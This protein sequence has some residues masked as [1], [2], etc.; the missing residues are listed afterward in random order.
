MDTPKIRIGKDFTII[1]RIYKKENEVKTPY[2]L[3]AGKENYILRLWTP[4]GKQEI[5][6]FEINE[7]AIQ[8]DFLGKD[9]KHLGNYSLELIE[10]KNAIGM[11]TVDTTGFTLVAFSRYETTGGDSDIVIQD[12]KLE[13]ELGLAPIVSLNID[14]EFSEISH[15]A[16]SN[17]VITTEFKKVNDKIKDL[18]SEV[19]KLDIESIE[20]AI[21]GKQDSI[22]DLETIRQGAAKG[23]TAVQNVSSSNAN[24]ATVSREGFEWIITPRTK[25]ISEAGDPFFNSSGIADAYDVK[26]ELVK[27]VDKLIGKQLSTEDFTT[28]LKQKLQGLSNYDDSTLTSAINS[29]QSQINTLVSGNVSSAIDTFN[30]I[31]AF[32]DGVKDTQDL[33]GIIASIEQQIAGVN[34]TLSA[35]LAKKPNKTDIATING[36]L[37]TNG[38]NIVIEGK[39]YDAVIEQQQTKL[40]ELSEEVEEI[41]EKI[42]NLPQG[43]SMTPI[44]YADLV[45]LRDN[46]ELVAGSYYRITDYITTTAQENTQSACHPFDVIVLALSENTIAEEAYAIQSARD[47]DGYFANSNLAAWKLWYSLDNNAE[48]FAWA[49]NVDCI[50]NEDGNK[51]LRYPS[52]DTTNN[53]TSFCAWYNDNESV[54]VYTDSSYPMGGELVYDENFEEDWYI[55]EVLSKGKGVIYR[56]IDEW[57]NDVPYDFKNIQF[58]RYILEAADA[59]ATDVAKGGEL[60][61]VKEKLQEMSHKIHTNFWYYGEYV[62]DVYPDAN[63][64]TRY[65]PFGDVDYNNE[66]PQVLCEI[67]EN[68]Y[69]WFYT[70]HNE[71][72]DA[73]LQKPNVDEGLG[74]YDNT[75]KDSCYVFL[76]EEGTGSYY[77]TNINAQ[78]LN[79]IV[80]V[81]NYCNSNSFGNNCYFNSFGNNCYSNSFGNSCY[82]N[83][84]GNDCYSNSFGNNCYFNSFGN[85]C[86]FNSF[87]NDC[88]SNS[89]KDQDGIAD[90]ARYNKLDDGVNNIELWYDDNNGNYGELKNHHVC[91]GCRNRRIEIY[92][93][94]DYETTYTMT[95]DGELREFVLGDL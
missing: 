34:S 9:Q 45:N 71:D 52:R 31:I 43:A 23:A 37:L 74:V 61:I 26:Q 27:K 93:N 4:Y 33:A 38:G 42:D 91:R 67:D 64:E 69:G 41:N 83:S 94:R 7:N 73:S 39:N 68:N 55:Q 72:E 12:V 87:G 40:T 53:G 35:E 47:T 62:S 29:L 36:Q 76:V 88:Y 14:T 8:F 1:W 13:T 95:S 56:M 44:T 66:G 75:I 57:N 48:R 30:E 11:V 10:R 6:R 63:T 70:F 17:Y 59:F 60:E 2:I 81:G 22:E 18:Q 16:V 49:S 86:N 79:N 82:S 85:Y 80:F 25:K 20:K 84:F 19:E 3:S 65:V 28:A 92:A 5:T 15:N 89:F 46:G 78:S 50:I 54:L 58:K 32:L 90:N 24:Y 51:F 77:P 21:E